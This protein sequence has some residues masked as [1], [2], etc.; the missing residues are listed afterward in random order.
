[1]GVDSYRQLKVWQVGMELAREAY[2]LTRAF[3]RQELYGLGGQMQRAAVSIPA[4]V[5]EGHARDST[6]EFLRHL[7]IARG[8]LAELETL[9]LLAEGLDYCTGTQIASIFQKCEEEG[10]MLSGLQTK[11]R[12]KIAKTP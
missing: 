9:L 11:L 8:S 7:S 5:A 10:R 6:K 12:Q 4:N 3:P 1:M 2:Q